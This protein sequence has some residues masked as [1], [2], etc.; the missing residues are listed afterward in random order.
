MRSRWPLKQTVP[1]RW[2]AP[3]WRP[4]IN[5]RGASQPER[6]NTIRIVRPGQLAPEHFDQDGDSARMWI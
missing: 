5:F 4:Q 1:I 3:A 6:P 2:S